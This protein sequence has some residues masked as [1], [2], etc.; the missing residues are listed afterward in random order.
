VSARAFEEW[1]QSVHVLLSFGADNIAATSLSPDSCPTYKTAVP[2]EVVQA[3]RA[4]C[5]VCAVC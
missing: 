5:A 4:V 3:V 1:I 2:S